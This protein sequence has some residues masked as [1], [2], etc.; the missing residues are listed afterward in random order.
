MVLSVLGTWPA[1]SGATG[2]EGNVALGLFVGAGAIVAMAWSFVLAVRIRP[3][4][5]FFGGLDSMYRAHRWAGT[6]AVVGTFAHTSLEPEIKGGIRGV[7]KDVAEAAQDLAGLGE[8][9]LYALVGVSLLRWFPY[10]YWR[11]THK[12]LGVPFLFSCWHFYTTPK[13]YANGSAWGRYFGAIMLAGIVAWVVRVVWRDMLAR[14]LRYRIDEVVRQGSTTELRLA[15]VGSPLRHRPGQF[16]VL[17]IQRPGLTEPH[18]FTIASSPGEERLRFFVRDLGDWTTKIGLSEPPGEGTNGGPTDAGLTGAD[19]IVEG[20]YG[21]FEPLPANHPES[22]PVFWVAGGVGITPFLSAI[23]SLPTTAPGERPTLLYCVRAREEASAVETVERA[24]AE[25][26]IN[27]EWFE[28][29]RG[30]RLDRSAFVALTSAGPTTPAHVAACGPS[31]LV[32]SVSEAARS[33]GVDRIETESFDFRAGFGPDLSIEVD[34]LLAGGAA[35]VRTAA[36]DRKG[37]V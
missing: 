6:L 1:F 8:I 23:Q 34:Q 32:A 36:K 7:S 17:K 2:E 16:A 31:A 13:P 37:R 29:S 33:A 24:A 26:R 12:L 4:E 22:G 10:R 14:G 28:S 18:T 25:G 20:P 9:M 15:P 5:P 27:L 11:W 3:L 19:V 35:R 30:R 21:R